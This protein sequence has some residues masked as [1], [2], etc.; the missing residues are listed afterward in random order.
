[1]NNVSRYCRQAGLSSQ[2]LISKLRIPAPVVDKWE[3]GEL[4]PPAWI[5]QKVFDLAQ[6]ERTRQ[7]KQNR[8]PRV[9]PGSDPKRRWRP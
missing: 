8:R 5:E 9:Q 1:M 2:D 6:K 3:K 4:V 7:L